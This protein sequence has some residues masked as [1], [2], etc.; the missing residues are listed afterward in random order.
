MRDRL[1]DYH[2]PEWSDVSKLN[3]NHLVFEENFPS[4]KKWAS[5]F[6]L[7]EQALDK[8]VN[9]RM[10]VG[11]GMKEKKDLVLEKVMA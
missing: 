11:V 8:G 2:D 5:G 4:L 7:K 6:G 10:E 9:L 3:H 1:Q